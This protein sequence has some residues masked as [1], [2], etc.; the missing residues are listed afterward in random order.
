MS[1]KKKKSRKQRKLQRQKEQRKQEALLKENAHV[2]AKREKPVVSH[3]ET[4]ADEIAAATEIETSPSSVEVLHMDNALRDF[5]TK[6][7]NILYH[8]SGILFFVAVFLYFEILFHFVRV[9]A[10]NQD[11]L[12]KIL[13]A[14][15]G[16]SVAGGLIS[17]LKDKAGKIAGLFVMLMVSCYYI[18]Q[19]LYSGVFATYMSF[20]GVKDVAGQALDYTNIIFSAVKKEVLIVLLFALPVI[21]YIVFCKKRLAFHRKRVKFY[22]AYALF[23][24]I[25]FIGNVWLMKQN[26][27]GVYSAYEM[28][29]TYSS[30]DMSVEKLGVLE[31]FVLD[32]KTG[33]NEMLGI[34]AAGTDFVSE[35]DMEVFGD[36]T[37]EQEEASENEIEQTVITEASTEEIIDTTPNVLDIDLDRLAE[38]ETD[39]NIADLHQY[40]QTVTPTNQNEYTGMFKGYNVIFVVA[41]GFSGYVIDPERTPTLYRLSKEGFQ[42]QNYYTP[43]WY[44]STLGGEFAD[45]TGLIPKNG[46]YLSMQKVGKKNNNMM[47]TLGKQLTNLDYKVT[48]YHANSHTYYERDVSRLVLGYD[49]VAVGTGYE[50]ERNEQGT[51]LWPQSDLRLVEKTF[52]DYSKEEPFYTYYL[53]VSG[54]VEYSFDGNAMAKRHEDI[55]EDLDYSSTTKAYIACQYELELAMEKLVEYLETNQLADHTMIV[56]TADHVPYDNK[57]VVDELAGETLDETFDWYKNSLII[58]SGSMENPVVVDKCCSSIDILPTVSNLLG[59]PYDSRMLAGQDILSDSEGIVMFNDRSFITDKCRYNVNTNH[60][61]N[62]TGGDVSQEYI[63]SKILYVKNKFSLSESIVDYNYYQYIEDEMN[64]LKEK[65]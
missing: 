56:L 43:L 25:V 54:H 35:N 8:D 32:T 36:N 47:F 64:S 17:L 29:R 24:I 7:E 1:K 10:P 53:T 65:S 60:V 45:L 55:V 57:E 48:A 40:I 2:Q 21:L 19:I 9:G 15:I 12:Y 41:E 22:L 4:A 42:F 27:K 28:Y 30:V 52:D 11:L 14:I 31:S 20:W 61:E 37:R 62:T 38:K 59:L 46:G 18:A 50:P 49:W 23:I 3:K 33:I 6:K 16:G 58:W 5:W 44:G 63:D 34:T 13:F 51:A 26:H 39:E